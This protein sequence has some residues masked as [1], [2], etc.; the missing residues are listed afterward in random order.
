MHISTQLWLACF[1]ELQQGFGVTESG[2]QRYRGK[3][4]ADVC[5]GLHTAL[6]LTQAQ[7]SKLHQ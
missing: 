3:T 5:I 7:F 1:C 2:E 6:A 4:V